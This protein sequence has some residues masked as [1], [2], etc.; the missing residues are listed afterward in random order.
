MTLLLDARRGVQTPRVLQRPAAVRSSGPEAVELA[1]ACG[2]TLDEWQALFLDVAM[3]ESEDGS[4]AASAVGLIA[5]RQ[6]G[7][8]GAVEARE[9]YGLTILR[10][11]IIHTAQLFKTTRESYDRLLSLVEGNPD[12]ADCLVAKWASP[13]S[14]YEMRF[15]GGG[16]I[17]FIAR[18]RTS[19]RG[20]T[21]DLLVFDEAQ[22]L[23]DEA[24]GALLP[25]ISA[26]PG[27]Q[28]WYF[29]SAPDIG[30]TVLH[31]IRRRG[32][33]GTDPRLA[34]LEYS[35]DPDSALD[36]RDAWAQANPALG[37]RITE[38][39][40]VAEMTA[41]SPEMFA[42]ERL[43][44]SPDLADGDQV[45]PSEAWDAV[46]DPDA[47]A[48]GDVF[49]LDC[50]P[51]RSAAGIVAVGAGPTVEVV[52]YAPG[53]GWVCDRAAEL[54]E[55][56]RAPFAVDKNG[57]AGA[58]IDELKRRHVRLIELDGP[59][60]AHAAELFYDQ[61]VN[62]SLRIRRDVDLD[63]A[64]LGAM[65]R[66]TGD[67]WTWGRKASKYDISLLVAASAGV[68]AHAQRRKG[69]VISMADALEKAGGV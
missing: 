35:A 28:A 10:E 20:L 2:L 58:F 5:S 3:G 69:R 41:M 55:K 46:N 8:N 59:D 30:S 34:Y 51:E 64:V 9:L 40:I 50:N 52:D 62:G 49:A 1:A 25:T 18:S 53:V 63:T 4:W 68:W 29:G 6:N 24:Q 15:R 26:R 44:I 32:R 42:R 48:D 19:G 66:A 39:A 54:R 14:G 7:K 11:W 33:T 57:P 36:D 43:S 65:R 23:N 13:A 17:S 22:D 16:R 60:M 47:T 67:A 45:I 12:V 27:A 37:T 61:V 38:E 31:R 21:G 56:H